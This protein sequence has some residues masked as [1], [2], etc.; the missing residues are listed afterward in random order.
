MSV[1]NE[2]FREDIKTHE[3][4]AGRYFVIYVLLLI[5]TFGTFGV[6]KLPMSEPLHLAA[7]L[8]IAFCKASLVV[9]FFMHLKEAEGVN[10]AVFLVSIAFVGVMFFF[11]LVDTA[12]R[13]PLANPIEETTVNLPG[14][15]P[16]YS[17][18]GHHALGPAGQP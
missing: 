14:G 1:P 9:L 4:G 18:E 13:F 5:L 15:N 17:P 6:A 3:A 12:H 16:I 10:R 2:A 8:L 7:A 11:I